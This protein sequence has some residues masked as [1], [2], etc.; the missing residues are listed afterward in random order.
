[1]HGCSC[2]RAGAAGGE[3]HDD[4]RILRELFD[5]TG[6]M[7]ALDH[8]KI[9][10]CAS[11]ELCWP[12]RLCSTNVQV[13]FSASSGLCCSLTTSL[14]LQVIMCAGCGALRWTASMRTCGLGGTQRLCW[15]MQCSGFRVAN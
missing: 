15:H 8:N 3:G 12:R 2:L 11:S 14:R 5:G 7:G 9:E 6:I 13:Q 4:A 1:M 10:V